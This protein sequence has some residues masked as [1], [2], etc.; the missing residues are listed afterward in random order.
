MEFNVGDFN[1]NDRN[2]VYDSIDFDVAPVAQTKAWCGPG[3][4]R[5]WANSSFNASLSEYRRLIA[6]HCAS[7]PP[8]W[9][10]TLGNL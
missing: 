1:R 5:W 8:V 10:V 9:D 2:V 6:G 7:L 4:L 3:L